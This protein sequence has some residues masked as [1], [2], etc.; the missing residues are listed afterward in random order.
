MKK[1]KKK[2]KLNK[3]IRNKMTL[4]TLKLFKIKQKSFMRKNK[5]YKKKLKNKK[6]KKKVLNRLSKL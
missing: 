3:L 2:D 4:Q 1:I 6:T 5:K